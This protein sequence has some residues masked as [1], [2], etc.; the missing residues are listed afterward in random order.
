MVSKIINVNSLGRPALKFKSLRSIYESEDLKNM[1]YQKP[2]AEIPSG[3]TSRSDR[4]KTKKTMGECE[5]ISL[6]EIKRR[7]RAKWRKFTVLKIH[8]RLKTKK[9]MGDSAEITEKTM[10]DCED[11]SL[12][13]IKRRCKERRRKFTVRK[14]HDKDTNCSCSDIFSE[15]SYPVGQHKEDDVL[16]EGS[17]RNKHIN[18]DVKISE[19]LNDVE[20]LA[21]GQTSPT[22]AYSTSVCIVPEPIVEGLVELPQN[23][24]QDYPSSPVLEFKNEGLSIS[25]AAIVKVTDVELQQLGI[26]DSPSFLLLETKN[27]DLYIINSEIAKGATN[28]KLQQ[29]SSQDSPSSPEWDSRNETISINDADVKGILDVALKPVGSHGSP[30]LARAELGAIEDHIFIP[31]KKFKFDNISTDPMSVSAK[32]QV[33][34]ESVNSVAETCRSGHKDCSDGCNCDMT[35]ESGGKEDQIFITEDNFPTS[36]ISSPCSSLATD[37]DS[38]GHRSPT[39]HPVRRSS[40][41][42][43]EEPVAN[44][45]NVVDGSSIT[46]HDAINRF[47]TMEVP[48]DHHGG[49]LEYYSKS[50]FSGRKAISPSSQE[51]LLQ[52]MDAGVL[53][54][55]RKRSRIHILRSK[56]KYDTNILKNGKIVKNGFTQLVPKSILKTECA[57]VAT[58]ADKAVAFTQRQMHDIE[59]LAMM[60]M[61]HLKSM[62]EVVEQSLQTDSC[63]STQ[64]KYNIN[65]MRLTTENAAEAEKTTKKWISM[66]S[67]D[68]N[69]FCNILK[70][71]DK[72]AAAAAAS[73]SLCSYEVHKKRR[74]LKF[75]DETGGILCQVKSLE[76][77]LD[78]RESLLGLQN[79]TTVTKTK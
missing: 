9:K 17:A 77:K 36:Q 58:C 63:S 53:H 71:T 47:A 57:S 50:L 74:K 14:I 40:S 78:N 39:S 21:V 69:R 70:M 19:Y 32:T 49:K 25:H 64:L 54:D 3:S 27:D 68:C 13:E 18:S 43:T 4:L 41:P 24:S 52:A 76:D 46:S 23:R 56:T 16:L 62:K 11:I 15:E 48:E 8:D 22:K 75:A 6:G 73:S 26:Y 72:K 34:V 66:M 28:V 51:K 35:S 33:L 59:G 60:L 5:E 79:E 38:V 2:K 20:S 37:S 7:C 12:G 67:K 61:K 10:G 44:V 45:L 30:F 31:E 29:L 42:A 1:V 55:K 65:K